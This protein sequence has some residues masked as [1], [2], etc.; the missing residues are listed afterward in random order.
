MHLL[1]D[2][3]E[4]LIR[5]VA[6]EIVMPRFRNL[7]AADIEEKSPG[8]LVTIADKESELALAEGLSL[9]MPNARVIG[10]EATAAD[11]DVMNGINDGPVWLIDPIDGT[12]N[13]AEGKPPFGLMIALLEDGERAGGWMFDPITGRMCHAVAGGGAY[14]NGERIIARESG[15]RLPIASLAMHFLTPERREDVARRSNGK[16]EVVPIP[17]CAAEQYPR[18]TLGQNDIA[19]FERSLPWD[20]AAGALFVEE[21]GGVVRRIDGSAYR[22]GDGRSGLIG[23][24]SPRLWDE[25][26]TILFG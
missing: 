14:V 4:A 18:L 2:P 11:P 17:R 19:L 12:S 25:A 6:A 1:S 15:A 13:F 26:A 16:F 23:A 8:D 5:T 24:A 10:E 7:Q 21:A 3:V 9:I 22:V 20:H